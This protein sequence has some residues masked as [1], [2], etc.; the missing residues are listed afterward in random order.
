[1]AHP[2]MPFPNRI[3]SRMRLRFLARM[4]YFAQPYRGPGP[5]GRLP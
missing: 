5:R 2:T 4:F 3:N 1:L